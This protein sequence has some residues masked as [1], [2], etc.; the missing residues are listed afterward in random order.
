[1]PGPEHHLQR[2]IEALAF[3]DGG[4]HQI[5]KLLDARPGGPTVGNGV[6]E[7]HLTLLRSQLEMTHPE[8][9]VHGADELMDARILALRD[10][11]VEVAGEVH[12]P[13][14]FVPHEPE[15]IGAPATGQLHRKLTIARPVEGPVIGR[16][17]FFQKIDWVDGG[18]RGVGKTF[19]GV[20]TPSY[21]FCAKLG[22]FR[23]GSEG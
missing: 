16:D 18:I 15:M 9:F 14:L 2:G 17:Q 5:L 1:M 8:L 3:Q 10:L 11:E 23:E 12:T 4:V 20:G 21:V 13:D 6:A 22:A 19:H 7:D